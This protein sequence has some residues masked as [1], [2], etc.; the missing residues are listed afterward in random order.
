VLY[1]YYRCSPDLNLPVETIAPYQSPFLE[2]G[3][4]LPRS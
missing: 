4:A 1:L 3:G 2:K